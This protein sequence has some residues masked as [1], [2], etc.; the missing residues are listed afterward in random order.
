MA[1][2]EWL[3]TFL[4]VYRTGTITGAAAQRSLSQPAVSQQLAALE[5]SVGGPLFVRGRRG[6]EPTMR[7]SELY[8]QVAEP[9]RSL[10]PIVRRLEA[11]R[12]EHP[13][14][15][16]RFGASAEYFSAELLPRLPALGLRL[17]AR[18]GEDLELHDLLARG[19]LDLIVTSTTPPRRHLTA[20]QIGT[21]EFVLVAAPA[22]LPVSSLQSIGELGEWL[23]GKPWVSYSHELPLTRRFWQTALD[24]PFAGDLRLVVPDLRAAVEAVALGIGVSLLPAFVCSD[25]L[26]AGQIAEVHPVSQLAPTEPWFASTRAIDA[27][28]PQ[29]V[30]LIEALSGPAC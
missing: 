17:T 2:V 5:Q 10:E 4:A 7:G 20:T 11:G 13:D 30:G 15:A 14:A 18:L 6:V 24:L 12:I 3:R 27:A 16:V 29:L 28:E 9:L 22:L 25:A 19:E 8:A 26:A 23:Q 21:K 1:Q